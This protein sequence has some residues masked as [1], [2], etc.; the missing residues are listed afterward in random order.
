MKCLLSKGIFWLLCEESVKLNSG[1]DDPQ[2]PCLVP[3]VHD[4]LHGVPRSPLG[5]CG[6]DLNQ[7]CPIEL[8]A[9]ME[10]FHGCA[11]QSL[12]YYV[13]VALEHMKYG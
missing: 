13:Q 5:N 7:R 1:L 8:S 10:M 12:S 11:V 4:R 9:K 2:G 3:T 6:P